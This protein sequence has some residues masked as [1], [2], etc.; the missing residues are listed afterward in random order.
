M[1]LCRF[2]QAEISENATKCRYC[3]S[4]FSPKSDS[5]DAVGL[6]VTAP[7]RTIFS[8]DPELIRR[9]KWVA[10]AFSVLI[11]IGLLLYLYGF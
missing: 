1:K 8:V 5:P 9:A 7:G 2:C 3:L 6:R 4:S 11:A 10:I